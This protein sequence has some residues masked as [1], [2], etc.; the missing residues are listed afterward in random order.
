MVI[1]EEIIKRYFPDILFLSS[2]CLNLN[3]NRG[4]IEDSDIRNDN[5]GSSHETY[6]A[7]TRTKRSNKAIQKREDEVNLKILE[8]IGADFEKVKYAYLSEGFKKR[9]VCDCSFNEQFNLL[10][11]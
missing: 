8:N 5:L 3:G 6:V 10:V 2:V 4:D 1:F 11:I 7:F 9:Y